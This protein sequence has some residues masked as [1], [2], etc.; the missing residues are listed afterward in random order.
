MLCLVSARP[1]GTDGWQECT[2]VYS[3]TTVRVC[4]AVCNKP[5]F[6]PQPNDP[7]VLCLNPGGWQTP[8]GETHCNVHTDTVGMLNGCDLCVFATACSPD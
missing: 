7:T 2:Y 1:A 5:Y 3:G 6:T 8:A 4:T